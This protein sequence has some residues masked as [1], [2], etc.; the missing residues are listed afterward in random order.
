[1][2]RPMIIDRVLRELKTWNH[3]HLIKVPS[4][5]GLALKDLHIEW[6][7]RRCQRSSKITCGSAKETVFFADM[8]RHCDAAETS[9]AIEVDELRYRQFTV[10]KL[11]MSVQIS[12]YHGDS[13][14]RT[15]SIVC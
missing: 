6:K 9:R 12:E 14:H 15:F 4:P 13:L 10:A 3:Q 8:I 5:I 7:S 1:M 2:G 11:R